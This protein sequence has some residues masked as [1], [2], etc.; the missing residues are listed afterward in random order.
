MTAYTNA[1]YVLGDMRKRHY[2]EWEG[3][4][5]IGGGLGAVVV[6]RCEY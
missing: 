1:G 6:M 2:V 5:N 3:V 4:G